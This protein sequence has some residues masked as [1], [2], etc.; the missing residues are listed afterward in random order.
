MPEEK[1]KETRK[2]YQRRYREN[3]AN[4]IKEYQRRYREK[5]KEFYFRQLFPN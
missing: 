5:Q 2:E 4:K 3:N 1:K